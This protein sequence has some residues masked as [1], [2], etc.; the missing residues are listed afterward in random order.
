ALVTKLQRVRNRGKESVSVSGWVNWGG[1]AARRGAGGRRGSYLQSLFRTVHACLWVRCAMPLPGKE[2][3]RLPVADKDLGRR[4]GS[5]ARYSTTFR[6]ERT[7]AS[8]IRGSCG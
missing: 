2:T 6:V 3:G 5:Q 1:S 7:Y 4:K 8:N